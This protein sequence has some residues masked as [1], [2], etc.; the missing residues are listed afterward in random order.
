MSRCVHSSLLFLFALLYMRA[1]PDNILLMSRGS[2]EGDLIKVRSRICMLVPVPDI[3]TAC[4]LWRFA[5]QA[6]L[7]DIPAFIHVCSQLFAK[8]G[9]DLSA[10]TVG[11]PAFLSPE[12]HICA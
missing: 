12:L 11:S 5:G 3:V 1:Q 4:R 2:D 6:L 8:D 10:K 9:E 7:A